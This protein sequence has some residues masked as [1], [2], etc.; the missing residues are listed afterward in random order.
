MYI[1]RLIVTIFTLLFSLNLISIAVMPDYK[2]TKYIASFFHKNQ[3]QLLMSKK[4]TK[5]FNKK[6]LSFFDDHKRFHKNY[7]I[8]KG[9]L[10]KQLNKKKTNIKQCKKRLKKMTKYKLKMQIKYLE[11]NRSL[12]KILNDK[13]VQKLSMMEKE[14]LKIQ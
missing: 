9:K 3:S 12:N 4:Q 2:E 10:K 6:I 13:Q 7:K 11:L 14:A 8:Q 5:K 1:M